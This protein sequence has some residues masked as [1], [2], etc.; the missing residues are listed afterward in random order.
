MIHYIGLFKKNKE[1]HGTNWIEMKEMTVV[2]PNHQPVLKDNLNSHYLV[3]FSVNQWVV[4][5][6]PVVL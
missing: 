6:H 5:S 3:I 4:V 2:K 1:N